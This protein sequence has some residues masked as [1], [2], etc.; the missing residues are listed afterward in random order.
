MK[1]DEAIKL[2]LE[3]E[4]K[5]VELTKDKSD[6]ILT[7]IKTSK[8]T[9]KKHYML[10]SHML[11]FSLTDAVEVLAAVLIIAIIPLAIKNNY[12]GKTSVPKQGNATINNSI[13]NTSLESDFVEELNY[14]IATRH[15]RSF[16]KLDAK[17]DPSC[18]SYNDIKVIIEKTPF[19][20]EFPS[21][22]PHNFELSGNELDIGKSTYVDGSI[23]K[24]Y[25]V[26]LHYKE[27][28]GNTKLTIIQSKEL[29]IPSNKIHWKRIDLNGVE[30]WFLISPNDNSYELRYTSGGKTFCI[31]GSNTTE[32]K[33]IE[34][35]KVFGLGL[36]NSNNNGYNVTASTELD[37][38]KSKLSF[39]IQYPYSI[40]NGYTLRGHEL[41]EYTNKNRTVQQLDTWYV[42][43]DCQGF[44]I[45]IINDIGKPTKILEKSEKVILNGVDAWL[46]KNDEDMYQLMFWKD[47]K[48]F[49]IYGGKITKTDLIVMGLDL[50]N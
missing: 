10:K 1:I 27:K 35:T 20:I 29:E 36:K 11:P 26:F 21:A 33:F 22:I 6:K 45:L 40:P 16:I 47:G 24:N 48:Y 42:N 25:T 3:D 37:V 44:S 49:N 43:E 15:N 18:E 17:T 46:Y 28:Y 30:A 41:K 8:V 14:E 2:S 50:T 19:T 7:F 4:T 23:T 12:F 13:D 39:D 5:N 34:F 31:A 38:I 9:K 32:A